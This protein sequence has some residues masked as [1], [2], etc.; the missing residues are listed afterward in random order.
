MKVAI[1]TTGSEP[2]SEVDSRFGRSAWLLVYDTEAR[3][4]ETVSNKENVDAPQGAGI[5]T[6]EN[7]ARLEAGAIIT[8]HCG[9]NAYH[10]LSAAGIKV[11]LGDARTAQEAVSAFERGQ[12]QELKAANG[13]EGRFR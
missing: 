5:R 13:P 8:G 2:A 3:S 9:P 7:L 12:L 10:T 11:Y 1:T 6:E 4:W